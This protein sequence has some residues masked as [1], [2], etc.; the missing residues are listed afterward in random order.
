MRTDPHVVVTEAAPE[1]ATSIAA[2]HVAVWRTAYAGILPDRVLLRLSLPRLA[3]QYAA[4]IDGH[5]CL[6]ARGPDD[7]VVGFT[8]LAAGADPLPGSSDPR[9]GEVETLYV[10]DDHRDRG[11]GRALLVAAGRKLRG[12]ACSAVFLNV[13]ADNNS[14]WFYQHLGGVPRGRSVTYVGGVAMAQIAMTWNPVDALLAE[15]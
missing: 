11:I 13:L 12:M 9:W 4:T 5:G 2:V 1:D 8:T 10:H 6:V 15:G 7:H 14:R 3:A